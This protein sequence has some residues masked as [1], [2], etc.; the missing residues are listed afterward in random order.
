MSSLPNIVSP[1]S[2]QLKKKCLEVFR[3]KKIVSWAVCGKFNTQAVNKSKNI[4]M[5]MSWWRLFNF[6]LHGVILFS[7]LVFVISINN[8]ICVLLCTIHSL[9]LSVFSTPAGLHGLYSLSYMWYSAFNST[10]VVLI[11]LLVS[12]ITGM[13]IICGPQPCWW[14]T[15]LHRTYYLS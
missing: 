12:L 14:P 2:N 11:G 8:L 10:V 6:T 4:I 1:N 7:I 9:C 13:G 3:K 15:I 5:K